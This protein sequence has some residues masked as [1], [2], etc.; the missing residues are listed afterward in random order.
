MELQRG[1]KVFCNGYPGTVMRH[2]YQGMYEIRLPGGEVCVGESEFCLLTDDEY[3]VV[4][5]WMGV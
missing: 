5:D 4:R 3:R 1:Q 2:Y